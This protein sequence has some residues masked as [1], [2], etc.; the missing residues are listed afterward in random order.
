[1]EYIKS[2]FVNWQV[3][4]TRDI[5]KEIEEWTND[6]ESSLGELFQSR[7]SETPDPKLGLTFNEAFGG[8]ANVYVCH[9][10][11][12]NFSDFVSTCRLY[13]SERLHKKET[14][15][16]SFWI[17]IFVFNQHTTLQQTYNWFKESFERSLE[18]IGYILVIILQWDE[19][20][21]LT[22]TWCL[23][24][25][26]L[27]VRLEIKLK[28]QFPKS[29][30]E[31]FRTRLRDDIDFF[32]PLYC[33]SDIQ[34]S[35]TTLAYD[36][37][38]IEEDIDTKSYN[39]IQ[40]V[41]ERIDTVLTSWVIDNAIDQFHVGFLDSKVVDSQVCDSRESLYTLDNLN[42]LGHLLLFIQRYR[43]AENMFRHGTYCT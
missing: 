40:D 43:D 37:A 8:Q 7:Y 30:Y 34:S 11:D 10:W 9:C 14:A 23:Y 25:I 5:A 35:T 24:E 28:I 18:E 41:E 6:E 27:A 19:P 13:C 3:L 26:F 4:T 12:Y 29:A 21:L 15:L 33:H 16:A 36:H 39:Q 31:P 17:D 22:R 32:L 1:M 20:Y 2:K 38:V 42:R